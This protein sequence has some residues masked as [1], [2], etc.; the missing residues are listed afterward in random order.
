M[1]ALLILRALL[2]AFAL[3]QSVVTVWNIAMILVSYWAGVV[4]HG[5]VDGDS[6]QRG[7]PPRR[8]VW[9]AALAWAAFW[10]LGQ[11]VT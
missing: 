11:A 3:R 8:P 10:A 9:L 7:R 5:D 1:I 2:L 6:L 4:A